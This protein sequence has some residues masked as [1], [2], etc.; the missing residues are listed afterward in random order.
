MREITLREFIVPE[1]TK[2]VLSAGLHKK[3]KIK[4]LDEHL[5]KHQRNLYTVVTL[6]ATPISKHTRESASEGKTWLLY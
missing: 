4:S 1:E 5:L 3:L 6:E 2:S